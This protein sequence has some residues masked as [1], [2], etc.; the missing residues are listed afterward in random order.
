MDTRD[1]YTMMGALNPELREKLSKFFE[2][3]SW[4]RALLNS[5]ATKCDQISRRCWEAALNEV[6]LNPEERRIYRELNSSGRTSRRTTIAGKELL[7]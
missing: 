3:E 2:V 5:Y 7:S 4:H 1:T 6:P